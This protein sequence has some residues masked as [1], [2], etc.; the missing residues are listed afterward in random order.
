[1]KLV[2]KLLCSVAAIGF[3]ASGFTAPAQAK[4]P[5]RTITWVV[6]FG[7]GGGTDRWSRVMSSAGFDVWG[8]GLRV[9][10]IPGASGV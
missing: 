7:A 3:L 1:M 6:P 4:Y 10:N 5:K 8:K 9:R 2:S